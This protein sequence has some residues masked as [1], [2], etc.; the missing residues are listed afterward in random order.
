[1]Y[2][3]KTLPSGKI[4][5][6][7]MVKAVIAKIYGYE[8]T[9]P[10]T[11]MEDI[12]TGELTIESTVKS[13]DEIVSMHETAREALLIGLRLGKI[14]AV[15]PN[16]DVSS[17]YWDTGEYFQTL[18]DGT[19]QTDGG[20]TEEVFVDADQFYRWLAHIEVL[21]SP[22]PNVANTFKDVDKGELKKSSIKRTRSRNYSSV[23]TF[24]EKRVKAL[25][26]EGIMSQSNAS[27]SEDI[28]RMMKNSEEIDDSTIPADRS[29]REYIK[30]C[31]ESKNN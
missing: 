19:F 15:L 14:R 6:P 17:H 4:N 1:M 9:K 13:L 16:A 23:N 21:Q 10:V 24:L 7:D 25:G 11:V 8:K 20:E 27:L 26:S 30:N 5:F 29:M 22:L 3:S 31:K 18:V 12:K 2:P 28:T